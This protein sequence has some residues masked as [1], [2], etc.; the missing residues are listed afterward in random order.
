[1]ELSSSLGSKKY[2]GYQGFKSWSNQNL[3]SNPPGETNETRG[4]KF[5][6]TGHGVVYG[7]PIAVETAT[8][9]P[10]AL[11]ATSLVKPDHF[12]V[13]DRRGVSVNFA[14][15]DPSERSKPFLGTSLY[16]S[17]FRN[18]AQEVLQI[19]NFS[20]EEYK[21][22]FDR[23]DTDGNGFIILKEMR[24]LLLSV[25][26][27]ECP[28]W[29][30]EKH[31]KFFDSNRDGKV[32]WQE[33]S[34]NLDTINSLV[35]DDARIKVQKEPEWL[36]ASKRVYPI[37]KTASMHTTYQIDIGPRGGNPVDRPYTHQ[38][39]MASTTLDL[40]KGTS[41]TTHRIPGYGGHIPTKN[42]GVAG[43]HGE[44]RD[45][46]PKPA[47]LRLYH[48]HNVPGY[49]GHHPLNPNNDKGERLTGAHPGTS[50]GAASLG[51]Q[52]C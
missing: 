25:Y 10:I 3:A 8:S 47:N 26:G 35:E 33:F 20:Q 31:M 34:A 17:S 45:S 12:K 40:L 11:E 4:S 48:S 5:S 18:F 43:S 14:Y 28:D 44:G 23:I 13:P 16:K 38:T 46:H 9:R 30:V 29:V 7:S 52:L 37:V 51:I 21:E 27:P 42:F 36:T 2:Y 19:R 6:N 32:T 41:S 39:G 1:M 50:S 22:A 24:Q 49:T 15:Q